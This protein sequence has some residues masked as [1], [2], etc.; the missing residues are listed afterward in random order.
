MLV[1]VLVVDPIVMIMMVVLLQELVLLVDLEVEDVTREI[2]VQEHSQMVE[3]LLVILLLVEVVEDTHKMDLTPQVVLLVTEEMGQ[4]PHGF[5]VIY[6]LYLEIHQHPSCITLVVEAVVIALAVPVLVE[7]EEVVMD[8]ETTL[9]C[10]LSWIKTVN[11]PQ[12]V[13]VV[14]Q[15]VDL[16]ASV[17]LP[18]MPRLLEV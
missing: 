7:L 18:Y 4:A 9:P 10:L 13:A 3:V 5:Q 8:E 12:V 6:P 16:L 15:K 11:M 14:E 2:L 17:V 1:V